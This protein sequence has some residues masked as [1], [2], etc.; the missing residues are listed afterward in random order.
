MTQIVFRQTILYI[1][2]MSLTKVSVAL[3]K[4]EKRYGGKYSI[5]I[6]P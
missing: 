1:S 3:D 6:N 5:E 4:C 2:V